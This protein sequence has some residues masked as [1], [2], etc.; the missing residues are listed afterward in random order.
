[1][2]E[3]TTASLQTEA[4]WASHAPGTLPS[5]HPLQ[6]QLFDFPS[7]RTHPPHISY[8]RCLLMSLCGK[9]TRR[10]PVLPAVPWGGRD[11]HGG[12]MRR[13][14]V[15]ARL[16]E[17]GRA[18][19]AP[20]PRPVGSSGGAGA[21]AVAPAAVRLSRPLAAR[22]GGAPAAVPR[23]RSPPLAPRRAP[24][25]GGRSAGP[26]RLP[27]AAGAAAGPG[28]LGRAEARTAARGARRHGSAC[29]GE[30]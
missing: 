23:R 22:P 29:S 30:R 1:M 12:E 25:G 11:A 14:R 3:A 15:P 19:P 16:R 26:G 21:G 27:A 6:H 5:E 28:P 24:P 17:H 13:G 9:G 7:P 8:M 2:E 10:L 20:S 18:Q 4:P